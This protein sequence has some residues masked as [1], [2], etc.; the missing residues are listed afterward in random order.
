MC[1]PC[2]HCVDIQEGVTITTVLEGEEPDLFWQALGGRKSYDNEAD[3]MR[4]TRLFRLSNDQ[5]FFCASEKCSDF[6]Q[7]DLADE[8]VMLL[9]TGSQVGRCEARRLA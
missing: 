1:G 6:C 9:D 2:E 3:F 5:G 4:F 7:D 8:D